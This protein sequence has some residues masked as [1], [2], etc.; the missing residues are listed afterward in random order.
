M[1]DLFATLAELPDPFATSEAAAAGVNAWALRQ[2]V[3]HGAVL[4]LQRG[5]YRLRTAPPEEQRWERIRRLHLERARQALR[6]HRGHALSH[7]TA[8]TA[9]GWWTSLHPD[10]DVHLT[11]LRVQP[12]TRRVNGLWLHHSDSVTNDVEEVDGMPC[13]TAARTVADCLRTLRASNAVAVADSALRHRATTRREVD[14][15]LRSQRRWVGRPRAAEALELV[16]PRRETWLESTSFVTLAEAGIELPTPQV[17]VFDE[18]LQLVGRVDGMWI[19]DGTVGEADGDGKY[20]RPDADS[21]PDPEVT[22]RAILAERRRER[23]VERTGLVM[24]RWT[25]QEIRRDGFGVAARVRAGRARGDLRRF[26]GRLRVDGEWL[27]LSRYLRHE[28][29]PAA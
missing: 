21:G 28:G 26:R 10:G 9:R 19:A 16:D 2:L 29:P 25:R 23:A 4:R 12:R 20:L 11:A 3:R 22:S 7:E 27:D 24:V 5:V 1:T 14:A 13:L 18:H 17:E 15:A 8:A 6:A